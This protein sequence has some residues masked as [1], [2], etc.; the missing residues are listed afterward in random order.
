MPSSGY[1]VVNEVGGPGYVFLPRPAP[2]IRERNYGEVDSH[3][4][5]NQ[6]LSTKNSSLNCAN[7]FNSDSLINL[8]KLRCLIVK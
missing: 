3:W 6:T 8:S 5:S 4:G 1:S 7:Y 2:R